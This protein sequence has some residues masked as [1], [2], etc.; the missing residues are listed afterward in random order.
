MNSLLFGRPLI[1]I[2]NN[3]SELF[4]IKL[5]WRWTIMIV[6]RNQNEVSIGRP[7]IRI[8]NNPSELLFYVSIN[9]G[10]Q[11]QDI[12]VLVKLKIT[13]HIYHISAVEIS[14]GDP[15]YRPGKILPQSLT[16][17][18]SSIFVDTPVGLR[19]RMVIASAWRCEGR[20]FESPT[21]NWHEEKWRSRPTRIL[22]KSQTEKVKRPW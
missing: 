17:W 9:D 4:V 13:V 10:R 18:H 1:R 22:L 3:P 12:D 15:L 7:L 2:W 20:G 16:H 11:V 8:W 21:P 14:D 5:L 19:S 6:Q